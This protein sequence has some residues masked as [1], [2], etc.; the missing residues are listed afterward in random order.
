MTAVED[1]VGQPTLGERLIEGKTKIMYAVPGDQSPDAE[2]LAFMVHK[3]AI[4]AGDGAKRDVLIDKGELSCRTTSAV[5][6]LLERQRNSHPLRF[7]IG[8]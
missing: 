4:T 8:A 5:Y 2:N 1:I 6:Q 3:D 7:D